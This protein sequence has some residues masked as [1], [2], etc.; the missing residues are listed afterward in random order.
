VLQGQRGSGSHLTNIDDVMKLVMGLEEQ[1][2]HGRDRCGEHVHAAMYLVHVELSTYWN[3][4]A[5]THVKTRIVAASSRGR[6]CRRAEP[7]LYGTG[8]PH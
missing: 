6:G 8:Y 5:T 4:H 7:K 3:L 2:K 1:K